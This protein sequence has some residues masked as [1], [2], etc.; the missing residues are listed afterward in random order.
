MF[1]QPD[2]WEVTQPGV[3]TNRFAYSGNDPV[4]LS[5]PGGNCFGSGHCSRAAN[6]IGEFFG[7]IR[8]SVVA[9]FNSPGEA[10]TGVPR[11]IAQDLQGIA[12]I[13]AYA[14][15]VIGSSAR[16]ISYGFASCAE[17]SDACD[18]YLN[19]EMTEAQRGG[20]IV[21]E[22]VT[23]VVGATKTV[24]VQ[25]AKRI[26]S[27]LIDEAGSLPGVAKG[28]N[29]NIGHAADRAVERGVF[30][31]TEIARE[32]LDELSSSLK[33]KGWPEGTIKDPDYN[34][35]Y[36]VPVGNNGYASYQLGKN[37][38]AKLKTTLIRR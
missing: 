4:N 22:I 6:A 26:D 13:I 31:S 14:P 34:D 5:D 2:W 12:S 20:Y 23:G 7:G 37:G 33:S 24:S 8:D 21:F 11:G 15:G 27:F 25:G 30:E 36:L 17:N 18:E 10:A 38:T 9:A 32:K 1:I 29:S 16:T 3:G 35:R 28:V 19:G